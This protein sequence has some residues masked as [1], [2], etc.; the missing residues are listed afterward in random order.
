MTNEDLSKQLS[1]R[2]EENEFSSFE[3]ARIIGSRALQI[4]QG[5]KPLVKL[6][7]AQLEEMAYNPIE[8]AKKEFEAG[9][10]PITVQRSL[11]SLKKENEEE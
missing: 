5:A 1:N 3:K 6:T 10:I 2:L 7:K 4:S 8:M 9:K 11:P